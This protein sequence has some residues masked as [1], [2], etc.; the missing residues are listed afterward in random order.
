M[1]NK[2]SMKNIFVSICIPSYN[3]PDELNRLLK[4]IDCRP[5]NLEIVICEDCSPKQKKIKSIVKEYSEKA[6]Y[7]INYYENPNNLGFDG[8]LRKLLNSASGDY[9]IFM[10]DDDYFLPNKLEQFIR[11]LR[12]NSNI[13][14]FLRSHITKHSNGQIEYFR[15]LPSIQFFDAGEETVVWMLKRSVSICGFTISRKKALKFQTDK[16]DGTLLYQVYL[17]AQVCLKYNSCYYDEPFVHN[18]HGFRDDSPMFGSSISEKKKYTPGIISE[19]NSINFTKSYFE[20]TNFL[21]EKHQT[22][23]TKKVLIELSKYSYPFLSI[24]RKRG[25]LRFL[26]YSKRLENELGFGCTKYYH[27]YKWSL[28]F[29]GEKFCDTII[30]LIKKIIG[31]TPNL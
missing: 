16:L 12:K 14:Y 28:V 1:I 4:S 30:I 24:Q 20:L 7:L 17:M 18:V 29:F 8:N 5:E 15:Y 23:L 26:R 31:H 10:G 11:F 3:R 22:S 25:I 6:P 19:D 9:V 13:G 2:L 27:L 21:D